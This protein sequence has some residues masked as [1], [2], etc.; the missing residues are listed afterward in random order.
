[1]ESHNCVSHRGVCGWEGC[2]AVYKRAWKDD[3]ANHLISWHPEEL[4]VK[5]HPAPRICVFK[6][7]NK[8]DLI[9]GRLAIESETE[10]KLCRRVESEQMASGGSLLSDHKSTKGPIIKTFG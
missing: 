4:Q 1:M 6:H 3:F 7:H 8:C 9:C 5:D 10:E 2:K